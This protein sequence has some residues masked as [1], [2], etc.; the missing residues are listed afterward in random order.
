MTF[1]CRII[2]SEPRLRLFEPHGRETLTTLMDA[3][4]EH[5]GCLTSSYTS[6]LNTSEG[7][8]EPRPNLKSQRG[9]SKRDKLPATLAGTT[10]LIL[11]R[12]LCVE[13]D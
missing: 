6:A 5:H 4:P 12:S 7:R 1:Q 2:N 10:G 3:S 11:F 9:D 8:F 13:T